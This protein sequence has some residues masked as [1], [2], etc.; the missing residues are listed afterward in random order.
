VVESR[1]LK[2]RMMTAERQ[3][4]VLKEEKRSLIRTKG[5]VAD[6]ARCRDSLM[7]RHLE[8]RDRECA[9]FVA[10]N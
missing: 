3:V 8:A 1:H 4:A 5:S 7:Q 2:K 6:E 9:Q 10:L